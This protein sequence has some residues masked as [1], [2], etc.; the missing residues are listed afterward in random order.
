VSQS[1]AD[2]DAAQRCYQY[3]LGRTDVIERFQL[4]EPAVPA[5]VLQDANG[6]LAHAM[7]SAR[8]MPPSTW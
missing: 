8:A 4:P 6:L 5:V 3:A 7:P 2:L 1:V